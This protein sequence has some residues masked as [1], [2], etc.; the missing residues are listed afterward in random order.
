MEKVTIDQLL[1][2]TSQ[3]V[4]KL[5]VGQVVIYDEK[6]WVVESTGLGEPLELT[7]IIADMSRKLLMVER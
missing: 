5:I 2:Y 7:P 6:Y 1:S 4:T 3:K